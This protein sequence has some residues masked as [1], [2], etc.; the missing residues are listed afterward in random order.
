M[1]QAEVHHRPALSGGTTGQYLGVE[2]ALSFAGSA[3]ELEAL[4]SGCAVFDLSWRAVVDVTGKDRVRWLH[5]MVSNNVRDLQLN[6]GNY[7]FVLNAQGRILGDL[8]IFNRGESL[9]LETD[10]NQV[11]ALLTTLKRFIIMDKVELTDLGNAVS[12]IGIAGPKAAG[13]LA[14]LGAEVEDVHPLEVQDRAI[15]NIAVQVICG[16]EQKPNS[17]EIWVEALQGETLAKKI[18]DAGATPAG[19]EALETWRVLR[20]IPQYGKDIRDRDL[21]QETGQTQALNFNKGCYI[22]QEIVE[23]IRSRG[24]VHRKFTGFQFDGG[25]PA[26]GKFESEGRSFAEVTSTAG[27]PQAGGVDR[28]IGL[29]Y[30]RQDAVPASGQ[31]ELNG[32]KAEILDPPFERI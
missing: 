11:D 15:G 20:G 7:N 4:R 1:T 19:A 31:L 17:F 24:Q 6:S 9:L 28:Y 2:T 27:V 16:Q 13:I 12:A 3:Q 23:R 10:R 30:V 8:Y 26:I 29:G 22:G 5:N 21:P 32:L 18:R 14:A 25:L